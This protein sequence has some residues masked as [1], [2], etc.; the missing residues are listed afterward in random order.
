MRGLLEYE[1]NHRT[2]AAGALRHPFIAR[3]P[4]SAFP[5]P[6]AGAGAAAAPPIPP[7]PLVTDDGGESSAAGAAR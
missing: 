3:G 1:P 4:T 5:T 2:T 7:A 6:A